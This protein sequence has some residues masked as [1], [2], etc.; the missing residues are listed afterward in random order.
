MQ[1]QL[2]LIIDRATDGVVVDRTAEATRDPGRSRARAVD[3][4]EH[5]RSGPTVPD[6]WRLDDKTRSVGRRGVASARLALRQA[7]GHRS[8]TD[9]A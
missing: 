6:C 7:R 8:D 5:D 4:P 2:H 1:G 9:A 3:N